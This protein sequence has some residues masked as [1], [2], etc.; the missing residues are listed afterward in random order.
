MGERE[1]TRIMEMPNPKNEV[2]HPIRWYDICNGTKALEIAKKLPLTFEEFRNECPLPGKKTDKFGEEVHKRMLFW[3]KGNDLY[4]QAVAWRKQDKLKKKAKKNNS[5]EVV[6]LCDSDNERSSMGFSLTGVLGEVGRNGGGKGASSK[7]KLDKF[8]YG[9]AQAD[10]Q[11]GGMMG[12]GGQG[13]GAGVEGFG[14]C[15]HERTRARTV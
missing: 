9:A 10:R 1:S 3:L 11:G 2:R 7:N 8:A 14:E 4:D 6:D 5:S 15:T 13:G 12:Q